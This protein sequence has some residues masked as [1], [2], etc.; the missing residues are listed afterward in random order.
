MN[1][2]KQEEKEIW[3]FTKEKQWKYRKIINPITSQIQAALILYKLKTWNNWQSDTAQLSY[4]EDWKIT[5]SKRK[6]SPKKWAVDILWNIEDINIVKIRDQAYEKIDKSKTI[7]ESDKEQLKIWIRDFILKA[8]VNSRVDLEGKKHLPHK[9]F[10]RYYMKYAGSLVKEWKLTPKQ[11]ILYSDIC[12]A[13]ANILYDKNHDYI[14]KNWQITQWWLQYIWRVFLKTIKNIPNSG[15]SKSF[16]KVFHDWDFN[17]LRKE[18]SKWEP[19]VW[20]LDHYVNAIMYLMDSESFNAYEEWWSEWANEWYKSRKSFLN[21]L[22]STINLKD[23]HTKWALSDKW[24]IHKDLTEQRALSKEWLEDV[25]NRDLTARYKTDASKMLK[26]G[27][28]TKEIKDESWVRATYYG[29]EKD[30]VK[31]KDSI[32]SLCKN[33]LDKISKIKWVYIESIQADRKWNFIDEKW[34]NEIL[35]EL[36]DYLSGLQES[37]VEIMKR[38][39]TWNRSSKLDSVSQIYR[40]L[41][42]KSPSQWMKQAYKIASWEVKR[43]SNGKYEDFKLIVKY[44]IDK[45]EYNEWSNGEHI[46]EDVVLYQEVSFYPHGNDLGIWNHNFLDLEKRIFNRVKNMNDPELWKSISLNRLRYFTETTLKDISF[47]IDI[48]EDKIRRWVLPQPEND[49]YKYLDL[50][51]KRV[52]LDWL[53]SRTKENSDRF[54]ELIPLILNYFLKKNKIFYINKESD[55]FHG[56]ITAHQLHD[57]N[58]Y[59]IRR[60]STSDTLRNTALDTN[61]EWYSISFYT[62]DKKWYWYPNFYVINLWDLWDFISLEK[63]T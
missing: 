41:N 6:D 44:T 11:W 34:E 5:E 40:S 53:V 59:K 13:L 30:P 14:D 25:Q 10:R 33:Y 58:V 3:K 52:P 18:N 60:F 15:S 48:Y 56:L 47:D 19:I 21:N 31:I 35:N 24:I 36:E 50:D 2:K 38:V 17:F 39:K 7:E 20:T 63:L 45:N 16:H 49:N 37:N 26:I 46:D 8:F 43:W 23:E 29:Q 32:V 51:G 61:N 62:T 28:R 55:G 57:K 12:I 9:K 4:D 27:W 42:Q 22:Y 1:N 54:D